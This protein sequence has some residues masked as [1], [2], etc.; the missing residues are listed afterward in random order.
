MRGAQAGSGVMQTA[1]S[2]KCGLESRFEEGMQEE[3]LDPVVESELDFK[4]KLGRSQENGFRATD[5]R[6]VRILPP[7]VDG[8]AGLVE[9]AVPGFPVFGGNADIDGFLGGSSW[10]RRSSRGWARG[11]EVE[12][13]GFVGLEQFLLDLRESELDPIF[14]DG[15]GGLFIR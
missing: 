14:A 15:P 7:V 12:S 11:I 8:E 2:E 5:S 9:S 6:V 13:D 1:G 4:K 10:S 3:T